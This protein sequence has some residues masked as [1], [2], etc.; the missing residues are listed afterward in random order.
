M[1]DAKPAGF[2]PDDALAE[3]EKAAGRMVG[4]AEMPK[5]FLLAMVALVATIFALFHVVP[6]PVSLGLLLLGIPLVIWYYLLVR[7][8]PKP[9]TMLKH[10]GPY[11]GY[12]LLLSLIF[13]ATRFWEALLWWEV[14]AKWVVTFA[15]A[16]FLLTRLL[17]AE[18]KSRLK[19]AS[20]HPY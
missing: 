15:L 7:V 9:R 19:D 16:W 20:E 11:V 14:A 18:A 17:D 5:S 10:S 1:P 12:A 13:Q 4:A 6:M 8:R 3:V 2:G